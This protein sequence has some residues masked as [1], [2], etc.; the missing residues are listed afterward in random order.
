MSNS[1]GFL[2]PADIPQ[3]EA[4]VVNRNFRLALIRKVSD[5]RPERRVQTQ[6]NCSISE[7]ND[8]NWIVM[9]STHFF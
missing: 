9:L 4:F 3:G 6:E 7:E 1:N 2:K 5:Q 8:M